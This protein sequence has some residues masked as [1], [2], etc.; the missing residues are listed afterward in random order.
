MYLDWV[1][2]YQVIIVGGGLAGLTA[3]LEL[4]RSGIDVMVVEKATYPRHKVC[5]EYVSRE[6]IPYLN[7]LGVVIETDVSIDQ[8]VLT[9][10]KGRSYSFE[11]PLGGIGISRYALDNVLYQKCKEIGVTF[12]FDTATDIGYNEDQFEVKTVNNSSFQGQIVIAA[13]GKR[14]NLDKSLK[15]PFFYQKSP[16]LAV[17][18]HYDLPEFPINQ[19]ALHNFEGGYCGLSKTETGAVNMCYL[20]SYKNFSQ[21][22]N[23][24]EFNQEVLAENPYLADFLKEARPLWKNPLTIAQVSFEKKT[25][26]SNHILFCGDTAGLIHPLCGNGMAM[27][28]HSAKLAAEGIVRFFNSSGLDRSA[29]EGEYEKNWKTQFEQRMRLGRTLQHI[30]LR[31]SIS[32]TLI[33]GLSLFPSI[34]RKIIQKTHGSPIVV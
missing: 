12:C 34:T 8:F 4:A 3:A 26:V 14:S 6:V 25:A 30:L 31:E 1:K 29:L 9:T 23:I 16:W 15:R 13:H 19:V 20:A 10:Q 11:L 28:I 21:Y 17:K 27:A 5:G 22:R 33:S 18:T 2:D 32:R 24:D 7:K